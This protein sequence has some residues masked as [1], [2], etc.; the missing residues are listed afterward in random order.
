MSAWT[1]LVVDSDPEAFDS[2]ALT[3]QALGCV[4]FQARDA[5]EA[6]GFLDDPTL[7]IDVLLTAVAM[8]AVCG[9]E[10]AARLRANRPHLKVIYSSSLTDVIRIHGVVHPASVSVQ[11]PFTAGELEQ[12]VRIL[13]TQS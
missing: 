8:P 11:K 5:N 7:Q 9:L 13:L 1:A 12:K 6:L 2:A 3:L 10:L 4:V